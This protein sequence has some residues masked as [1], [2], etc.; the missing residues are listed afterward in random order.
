[1]RILTQIVSSISKH[2]YFPSTLAYAYFVALDC[3]F[4][5]VLRTETV[6]GLELKHAIQNNEN[7]MEVMV[8]SNEDDC[9][10]TKNVVRTHIQF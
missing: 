9:A 2:G 4:D 1:M 8:I 10:N 6:T 3:T 7:Q 5:S